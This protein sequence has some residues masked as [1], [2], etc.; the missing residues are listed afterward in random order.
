MRP[1]VPILVLLAAL[2]AV[3]AWMTLGED[4]DAPP[5]GLSD[6]SHAGNARS[7]DVVPSE[8]SSSAPARPEATHTP[9]EVP[10]A[11]SPL[12]R[13]D[14]APIN[15][16]LHVH[17]LATRSPVPMFQWRFTS[18][19][20]A[21]K[22]DGTEGRAD[23]HLQAGSAGQ[24]LIE[25]EGMSPFVQHL[26][27]PAGTAPALRIEA[28]LSPA[29]AATGITLLVHDLALQPVVHIRVDA[30]ALQPENRTEGAWTLGQPMW[31]RRT[32]AVDGRYVLPELAPGEY[33]IRVVGVHEDG[34]LLP[35]LPF[36]RKYELS[37]SNGF[38]EDVPLEPGC[39]PV[40]DIV[41]AAGKPLDPTQAG[42]VA[43]KLR[44]LGG[45]DV[46]RR[47]NVTTGGV[48]V[49]ATDVLPGVGTVSTAEAVPAGTYEFQVSIAGKVLVQKTVTLRPGD[50]PVER[51]ILP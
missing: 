40:F 2:A 7:T 12:P 14:A 35:L 6:T 27:V 9:P 1:A 17:D 11:A 36:A 16:A 47:W 21:A 8:R 29:A 4:G 23:L 37:G 20:A 44:I 41:D 30:F 24:M 43:L 15:V 38:V 46:S 39:V 48:A 3:A 25:A 22:G 51:V 10:T 34:S 28:F 5:P 19:G 32:S 45:A 50:L 33:G 42:V 18:E 13:Q 31:A 49:S 26:V